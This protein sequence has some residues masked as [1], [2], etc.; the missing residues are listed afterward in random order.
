M[1][2]KYSVFKAGLVCTLAIVLSGCIR[3]DPVDKINRFIAESSTRVKPGKSEIPELPQVAKFVPY[4][5][6]ENLEDPFLLKPFVR[7]PVSDSSKQRKEEAKASVENID[8]C[9]GLEC[10]VLQELMNRKPQFLE[11]YA[12]ASLSMV[13]SMQ[14]E[15]GTLSALIKTP[16]GLF[17]VHVGDYMG[18]NYGKV[19]IIE[20]D[21]MI[22]QE[23]VRTP[24]G[25]EDK[26]SVLNLV[27]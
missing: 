6:Q 18:Q 13:G 22:V 24:A 19:L 26:K 2:D 5:L 21:H 4:I 16:V 27:Y 8:S 3:E 12:L 20:P 17:N 1:S 15:D 7:D 14:E 11:R 23:K 10:A 9:E 25:W